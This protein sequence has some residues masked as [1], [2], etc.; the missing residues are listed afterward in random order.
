MLLE[1]FCAQVPVSAQSLHYT[2]LLI[3]ARCPGR[4]DAAAAPWQGSST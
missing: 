4:M 3:S 2:P 1:V